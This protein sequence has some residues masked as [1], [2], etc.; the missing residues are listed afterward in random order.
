M[1]IHAKMM[2]VSL[3]LSSMPCNELP[4]LKFVEQEK[5]KEKRSRSDDVEGE[6]KWVARL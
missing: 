1:L 6:S 3:L 5:K 4:A 2:S